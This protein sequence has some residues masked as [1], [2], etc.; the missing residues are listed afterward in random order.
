MTDPQELP[1]PRPQGRGPGRFA[2]P[3]I[4]AALLLVAAGWGWSAQRGQAEAEA[5]RAS[6]VAERDA[7]AAERDAALQTAQQGK[8]AL[9]QAQA[10]AAA[11]Q[12]RIAELEQQVH[13][14]DGLLAGANADVTKLRAELQAKAATPTP[15]AADAT[16]AEE[17]APTGTAAVEP[18][19]PPPEPAPSP[20]PERLTITFDVNSSYLP[21]SLDG[22]LRALA[23]GLEPRRSYAVRL[24]GAVGSDDVSGQTA[25]EARRYNRWMAERR[26]DR[27]AEYLE[28]TA[29]DSE[30]KIERTFAANDPSRQV[31][32]E[33]TPVVD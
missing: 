16:T 27:V 32:V 6:A 13:A 31:L 25:E 24:V 10:D 28:R 29:K 9:A 33:V 7:A 19:A 23:Q 15:S 22:R 20:E 1:E 14:L 21:D 26:V 18:A 11:T 3:A 5:A 4:L 2:V 12:T 17:P 8:D 30:L